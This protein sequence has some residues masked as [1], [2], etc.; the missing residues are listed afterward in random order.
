V[1]DGSAFCASCGAFLAPYAGSS[2]A[3]APKA[4][5]KSNSAKYLVIAV[6]LIMAV[7]VVAVSFSFSY[8]SEDEERIY[9]QDLGGGD[10][11]F[12]SGAFYPDSGV[13]AVEM[14]DSEIAFVLDPAKASEYTFYEWRLFDLDHSVYNNAYGAKYT[15]MDPIRKAEPALHYYTNNSDGTKSAPGAGWFIVAVKCYS[16]S[17]QYNVVDT[18][19]G[20]VKYSTGVERSYSWTYEGKDYSLDVSFRYQDF[21]NAR[22]KNKDGRWPSPSEY[23]QFI[24]YYD[25][26]VVDIAEKL[27]ALYGPHSDSDPGFANFVLAFDQICFAYP[28]YSSSVGPDKFLFGTEEYFQYPIETIYNGAGDCEDTAILAAAI[29]AAA[30]YESA[31]LILPGHAMAAVVVDADYMPSTGMAYEV[32]KGEKDG[33]TYVA[34]ETTVEAFLD[35]G[36]SPRN[37]HDGHPYSYY[38]REG[39]DD[40]GAYTFYPPEAMT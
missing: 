5:K 3:Y 12:L 22:N 11:L 7:A 30:G 28:P 19:E 20:K 10:Q 1:A 39:N 25:L 36:L 27:S 9:T 23:S 6:V 40:N 17:D 14:R 18:F 15:G 2:P 26:V 38:L 35:L 4:S 37:A 16:G 32:L 21:D 29:Y 13:L 33:L 31:I 24:E 34:G 8:L